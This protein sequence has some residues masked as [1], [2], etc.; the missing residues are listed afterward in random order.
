[1]SHVSSGNHYRSD[2]VQVQ[3][4]VLSVQCYGGPRTKQLQRAFV[5]HICDHMSQQ[6]GVPGRHNC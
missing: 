4:T 3:S 6:G 2:P 1:M 5:Q